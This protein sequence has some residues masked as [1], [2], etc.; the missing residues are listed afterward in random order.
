MED[1]P[2]R[3]QRARA[4]R[5]AAR[6]A[7]NGNHPGRRSRRPVRPS[8][9]RRSE[10]RPD[11]PPSSPRSAGTARPM[12]SRGRVDRLTTD[13][14]DGNRPFSCAFGP[15]RIVNSPRSPV[16]PGISAVVTTPLARPQPPQR[17][18]PTRLP[19]RVGDPG[20]ARGAGLSGSRSRTRS[21]PSPTWA[22]S[23]RS[24]DRSPGSMG[25]T[26]RHEGPG[27]TAVPRTDRP[28]QSSGLARSQPATRSADRSV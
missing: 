12:R 9:S 8:G 11:R 16:V 2:E 24:S 19:G 10:P 14:M 13:H 4:S 27:R 17:V 21:R 28:A 1:S 20:S 5:P 25:A 3:G 26:L 7:P 23:S 6:A 22:R 18:P 15:S